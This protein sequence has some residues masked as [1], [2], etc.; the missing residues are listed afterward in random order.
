[1]PNHA[2]IDIDST[3]HR[4]CDEL[5]R[6]ARRRSGVDQPCSW[7]RAPCEDDAV[8]CAEPPPA[9]RHDG[10]ARAIR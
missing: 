5:S 3:L 7:N 2:A 9:G 6:F 1:M 8:A 10:A 4:S